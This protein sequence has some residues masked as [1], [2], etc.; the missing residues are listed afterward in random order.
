[1]RSSIDFQG[2]NKTITL[3]TANSNNY[4]RS[5]AVKKE[6]EF[7]DQ[8]QTCNKHYQQ[9]HQ[10]QQQ[11]QQQPQQRQQHFFDRTTKHHNHLDKQQ[12]ATSSFSNAVEI[13]QNKLN[14]NLN[15]RNAT[16]A[17]ILEDYHSTASSRTVPALLAD[18]SRVNFLHAEIARLRQEMLVKIDVLEKDMYE[19][20]TSD[21]N[22]V[23]RS[24][25]KSTQTD[26]SNTS[27]LSL[28]ENL[29]AHI[30]SNKSS[31]SLNDSLLTQLMTQIDQKLNTLKHEIFQ[32][33]EESVNAIRDNNYVNHHTNRE[34][35][36][37][38][39]NKY[40]SHQFSDVQLT[41]SNRIDTSHECE[42]NERS[43]IFDRRM[44]KNSHSTRNN[45]H[46]QEVLIT[47]KTLTIPTA[48]A[49]ENEC[50][51][52]YSLRSDSDASHTFALYPARRETQLSAMPQS[53]NPM[54]GGTS[55]TPTTDNTTLHEN[56]IV[57]Y[58]IIDQYSQTAREELARHL[59]DQL[60]LYDD[61][62]DNIIQVIHDY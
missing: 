31:S 50:S 4:Q 5:L 13:Y 17:P 18:E 46:K 12:R 6:E 58:Q 37:A 57:H 45:E 21:N 35:T 54:T 34:S 59:V 16:N 33:F 30:D 8:H 38:S 44:N 40:A 53:D 7:D 25:H 56:N 11:Q 62:A 22:H 36:A 47:T 23:V 61:L 55:T 28:K 60:F 10:Q 48:T 42:N 26:T 51:R 41:A 49:S 2:D 29:H 27:S 24:T 43:H 3:T 39:S 15:S 32:K 52:D 19:Q 14:R 20:S 1:M 9:N